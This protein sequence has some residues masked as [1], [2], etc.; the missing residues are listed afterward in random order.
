MKTFKKILAILIIA[1]F[2][3]NVQ[4]CKK[5][6]KEP[7][8]TNQNDDTAA[9]SQQ[10]SDESIQ[11]NE[12]EFAMNDVNSAIENSSYG[13]TFVIVGASIDSVTVDKKLIITYSGN[14]ADES[15]KRAGQIIV[16]LTNGILWSDKNAVITVTFIGYKVTRNSTGKSITFNGMYT[17]TNAKGGLVRF[18][19]PNEIITHKIAGSMSISFDDGTQRSW[20]ITRQREIGLT[21]T[22]SPYIIL[23]GFGT[24]DNYTN[25]SVTGVNR[26]GNTFYSIITTPIIYSSA[27]SW[28]PINGA[29]M[30][31][32]IAREITVTFGV[33]VNGNAVVAPSCPYG[34][35]INWTN[36]LNVGKQAVLKY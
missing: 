4:S 13:K 27:C 31:K 10:S 23:S 15:R 7:D 14:N 19:K 9:Q 22:G 30:H 18:L 8:T 6:E 3:I 17:V 32:G 24:K 21:I 33:D 1:A 29:I 28:L 2:A 34:Y 11:T 12:S 5:D 25:V 35:K 36:I 20:T 16:Q 26:A